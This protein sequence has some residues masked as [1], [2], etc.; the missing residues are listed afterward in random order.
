LSKS[1]A[2]KRRALETAL[3]GYKEAAA[4]NVA[5]VT[6]QA[7]FEMAELYRQLAVDLMASE[8]P[9]NLNKD[10]L[11]QYDLLLEEQAT[12]FEEQA[13]KLHEA[14]AAR[15]QDGIYD[16][17]V[18]GSYAALAKLMPARFGKTELLGSWLTT[19]VL[20]D[21]A[22]VIATDP[23][24]AVPNAAV[25]PAATPAAPAIPAR[26]AAQFTR[27]V[28]Q[29]QA[30]QLAD[31]EL[32]FRQL[33]EAVPE[34][35]AASYNLGVLLRDA[36]R[37]EDAEAAFST[38]AT[39]Q[40]HSA[41]ALTDLGVVQRQRGKFQD[42]VQSYSRALSADAAFA[43]AL[44]NLAIVQDVY[45]GNPAAA[46]DGYE[47]YKALTG[48]DRP[49]TS[50]IADVKQRAGKAGNSPAAAPPAQAEVKP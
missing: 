42:A 44:R 41:Q 20:P 19:A 49:V 38:A 14:N 12:P 18:K 32:E 26:L 40:P 37:L 13:I 5:E 46:I 3:G 35:G 6:T 27:A 28:Q 22:P 4:Y 33:S 48:E 47:R 31:A 15:A 7:S 34:S 36:N 9:K 45:L 39:R 11:E 1:L 50:W 10:E 8:R 29:A 25:V 17:G 2:A 43:P 30:G 21:A 23:A 16:A 24:A